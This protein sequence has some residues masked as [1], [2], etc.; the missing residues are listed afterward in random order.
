MSVA[1]AAG[2][3]YLAGAALADD[4]K[5][6]PQDAP[7]DVKF[8]QGATSGTLLQVKSG[9]LALKK[10]STPDVKKFAQRMIDDHT[11][12]GLELAAL[13]KRKGLDPPRELTPL[14]QAILDR[15]AKAGASDFDKSYWQSQVTTH[16]EALA[17]FQA[18]AKHGSDV[19]LKAFAVKTLPAIKEHLRMAQ[20]MMKGGGRAIGG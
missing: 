9:E 18:E 15:L 19:D 4:V 10:S 6:S 1:L 12:V 5:K 7:M 14:H 8:V 11:K 20:E 17:L 2:L 13:A 3:A 16:E